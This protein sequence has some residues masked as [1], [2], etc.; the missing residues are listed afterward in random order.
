MMI[1][2]PKDYLAKRKYYRELVREAERERLIR[3]A[4]AGRGKANRFCS[5][6]LSRLGHLLVGWGQSMQER[7][8]H[9]APAPRMPQS[10]PG[11]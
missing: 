4:L 7:Y 5:R 8:G 9:I 10:A 6:A 11:K 1:V 2:T 3:E